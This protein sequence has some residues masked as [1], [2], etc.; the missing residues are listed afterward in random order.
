MSVRPS[1]IS[2]PRDDSTLGMARRA[3]VWTTLIT[4]IVF[5]LLT[6][7]QLAAVIDGTPHPAFT[8]RASLGE[9]AALADPDQPLT[10]KIA[11][12][13]GLVV[14]GLAIAAVLT[15]IAGRVL[16]SSG[17]AEA[18]RRMKAQLDGAQWATDRR[19]SCRERV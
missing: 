6:G 10:R 3:V 15:A 19:A 12:A 1:D 13:G 16:Q 4:A 9:L 11:L 7:V 17:L 18:D 5:G 2:R 8:I 14:V